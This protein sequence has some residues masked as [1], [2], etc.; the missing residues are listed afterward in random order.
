TAVALFLLTT[1][2]IANNIVNSNSSK[3]VHY[4]QAEYEYLN[5]LRMN[6]ATGTVTLSDYAQASN[7]VQAYLEKHVSS[8]DSDYKW[9]N[10]GPDNL[11]GR[12]RSIERINLNGTTYWYAGSISGGLWRLE[13]GK[14]VW[15]SVPS[16]SDLNIS[17]IYQ[18]AD[19][20]I[21]V[22]TGEGYYSEEFNLLPGFKGRGI[23][24]STNGNDFTQISS[25]IPADISDNNDEWFYINKVTSVN[26]KL[27][28]GTNTG[29][30][31]SNNMQGESW[32]VAK[33][34]NG[35]E[36]T[37]ECTEVVASSNNSVVA[38]IDE[39]A[40]ISTNGD[41]NNFVCISTKYFE[42][43]TAYNNQ[44]L[45]RDSVGRMSFAFA[46]SNPDY[47]YAVAIHKYDITSTSY[48]NERGSLKN[49]YRSVKGSNGWSDWKV[50][51]PGGSSHMFYVFESNGL[52]SLAM[53]VDPNNENVVYVGGND[54]WKG[55][56]VNENI[57]YYQWTQLTTFASPYSYA[58][59]PSNHFSYI[60]DNE[61]NFA[62]ACE[63]GV[64]K[65]N[66]NTGRASSFNL[67]LTTSQF[68]TV[69]ADI[70]DNFFGGSQGN[71]SVAIYPSLSANGKSGTNLHSS[72]SLLTGSNF[73][74]R[75]TGG[76]VHNSMISPVGVFISINGNDAKN[77]SSLSIFR[78]DEEV[79]QN[80]SWWYNSS[81]DSIQPIKDSASYITP[82]ILWE[83]FDY[84]LN[85]DSVDFI[86]DKNYVAGE[87]VT[88]YSK[89]ANQPFKITLEENVSSGQ[90]IRVQDRVASRFFVGVK[91]SI[92]M[93]TEA[94]NFLYDFNNDNPWFT[95]SSSKVGGVQGTPQCMALSKDANY[96]YVGT[97][98]GKLYLISNLA[99]A[100]NSETANV[101]T[102][103]YPD[104][105][106]FA[107]NPYCVVST[108]LLHTFENRVITSIIVD[109]QNAEHAIVTLGN[110]GCDD[111]IYS[112]ENTLDNNMS[113]KKIDF[114]KVPIY[115]SIFVEGVAGNNNKVMV[116][117]DFGI[118]TTDDITAANVQWTQE[119]N[120]IG[121]LPVFML[122]QQNVQTVN[123][124]PVF[125]GDTSFYITNHRAIFAATFGNGLFECRSL[126][127]S[128]NEVAGIDNFVDNNSMIIYPNPAKEFVNISVDTKFNENLTLNIYNIS[129]QLVK[130]M[131]QNASDNNTTFRVNTSSLQPGTYI[132]KVFG[133]NCKSQTSKFIVVK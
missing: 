70:F 59:V 48:I 123:E 45:P 79:P 64:Y 77:N 17:C 130:T 107:I 58:Y 71:G 118:W 54:L 121:Q 5:S 8:K 55:K 20:S 4:Y 104:D 87:I 56:Y 9:D 76:F 86:A 49:I 80:I 75:N 129:G 36:L 39:L 95:V 132:A 99:Y 100:Y 93:T 27:F 40:Y 111:Y 91:G 97:N 7:E 60:I 12:M 3:P 66:T 127:K 44:M 131:S 103:L 46:P 29:L 109:P 105:G 28:A 102:G 101:G 108:T 90:T 110:Y 13:E 65:F 19:G 35:Q 82:S 120:G 37:G 14:S 133:P 117:T 122:K 38:F 72:I 68:Y 78:I 24:R 53:I 63:T 10:V 22:G 30:K 114:A 69:S 81:G 50:I 126:V 32:A 83:N 31:V 88:A 92:L 94:S 85:R 47:L 26:N 42:N 25:T 67:N 16:A 33:T 73:F 74:S 18:A 51:G 112:F 125:Y 119:V 98:D 89:N 23:Y 124:Q 11:S 113:Y 96:L 128:G 15:N 1:A 61:N 41:P 115:T 2:F 62:I 106:T 6:P 57:D 116:G 21:Y 84:E 43:G 34:S 52:Y